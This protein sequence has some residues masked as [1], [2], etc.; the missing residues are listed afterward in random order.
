MARR[1]ILNQIAATQI[2]SK[3]QKP[4]DYSSATLSSL[5]WPDLLKLAAKK[6]VLNGRMKRAEIEK[7]LASA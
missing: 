6:G 2:P 3:A 7:A 1:N 5:T 4:A